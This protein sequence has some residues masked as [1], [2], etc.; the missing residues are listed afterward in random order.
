MLERDDYQ[1]VLST[2]LDY[3]LFEKINN[4]RD[5]KEEKNIQTAPRNNSNTDN[6]IILPDEFV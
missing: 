4:E 1:P 3:Q 2:K 5:I 6:H